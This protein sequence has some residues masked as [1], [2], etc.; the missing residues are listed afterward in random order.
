MTTHVSIALTPEQQ[1]L[2]DAVGQFAARHAPIDATRAGLDDLAA[3]RL[4]AWW[5]AWVDNGFH[6]VHLPEEVGGQGGDLEDMAAV[7]EAAGSALL[8]GPLLTT[9]IAGAAVAAHQG[10]AAET[11]LKEIAAGTTAVMVAGEHSAI[12]G[13]RDGDG[14][15]L[16]GSSGLTLG[17]CSAQ[18]LVVLFVD[19]ADSRL[20]AVLNAAEGQVEPRRGTDLTTDLGV[21]HLDSHAVPATAVLTGMDTELVTCLTVAFTAAAAAGI[22]QWCVD[23]VTGH[24]RTREQFGKPIGTFQALQHKAAMLLVNSALAT[25]AAW[26]AVRALNGSTDPDQHRLTACS[27]AVMAVMPV[28][29]LVL[30]ALTMLGAIGFTWEH[31]LHLY[32]RRATSLAASIGPVSRWTRNLGELSATATRDATVDLG[33]CDADFRTEVG[34]LLDRALALSDK[35]FGRQGDYPEF[36]IGARRELLADSGLIAPHWPAP[37]GRDATVRQQL[38]VDEEFGKRAGLVRP[39]VGIAEWILPSLIAAGTPELQ[40]RFVPATLRGD[41]SWCQLFSEPAAGSDLAALSTRAVRVDGGWRI[42]GHKIWTS[43]A[44]RAD[45]GALLA[46]TDPDAPKHRGIGY[47]ILDMRSP[48]VEFRQITQSS[49]RAEFNEVFLTDVFVPDEMLLGE[50]ASGWQL[51][52]STMAQERVAISGYV[53]IDRMGALRELVAVT[54]DPDPVLHAIGEID[55]YTNALKALG[56]RETLRLLDGQPPGPASSIAKVATNVMLRRASALT[57]GLTGPLALEQDSR[58]AVV[59]P[60]L[61]LP[62]ELI[63]GGTTEIQL[64]II[65][66]LILGLPRK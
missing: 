9:A 18:R 36:A 58:P 37:W 34:E 1:Q 13:S 66:Q 33:D 49:G 23:T 62:A 41:L 59:G 48:G 60:Y 65:A 2:G 51:A 21:L 46:R 8:P 56:V 43:L 4:P 15:R 22:T 10:A 12:R 55:A 53:N 35:G 39:S 52:I 6:A 30:E 25:A 11:L 32:W 47:F 29:G 27:A 42:N 3:G 19:E 5:D 40:Q 20:W 24:L 17:L 61:D 16:T 57:L 31:D 64:N 14:W 50:P 44:H 38:I 26:D 7:L 63:G 54:G 28:P 45:Y